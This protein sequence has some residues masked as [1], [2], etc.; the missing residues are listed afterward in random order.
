MAF[1]LATEIT[2]RLKGTQ[3]Q[4][5]AGGTALL[6]AQIQKLLEWASGSGTSQ[7][8]ELWH[9]SSSVVAA[10]HTNLDLTNL[11]QLDSAGATV[12]SSIAF[13][14]VKA[15]LIANTTAAATGGYL[16]VGG[17]TDGAAA[18]DAWAG[19]TTPF[20][21]DAA[22]TPVPAGG[23]F[24]WCNPVGGTVTNSTADILHLGAVSFDQTYEILVIGDHT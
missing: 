4:I 3:A 9:S 7:A 14:N 22:I 16:A 6:Q 23:A 15:I 10:A 13:A 18:A 20:A 17:G 19:V 24:M 21:A 11:T 1:T 5:Q 2:M 8:D 12:R